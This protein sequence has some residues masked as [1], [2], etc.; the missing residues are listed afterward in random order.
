MLGMSA[1]LAEGH[2]AVEKASFSGLGRLGKNMSLGERFALTYMGAFFRLRCSQ[3]TMIMKPP[4]VP[5]MST[6][7]P[8]LHEAIVPNF[9]TGPNPCISKYAAALFLQAK[10]NQAT[11]L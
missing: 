3:A 10:P 8:D 2:D 5:I 7:I 4:R 6:R 1:G 11:L 9:L